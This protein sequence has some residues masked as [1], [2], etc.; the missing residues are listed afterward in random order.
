[1]KKLDTLN[2]TQR[3]ELVSFMMSRKRTGKEV[4]RVLAIQLIESKEYDTIKSLTGISK[5]QA[6]AI[7]VRYLDQGEKGLLD[8]PKGNPK[9][10]LTVTQRKRV[11]Q[12][13]TKKPHDFG[14]G[15]QPGWTTAMLGATIEKEMGVVYKSKT[16]LYLL[17]KES[18]FS[19]HFPAKRYERRSNEEV[20]AWE[21]EK[22]SSIKKA[23]EDTNTVLL[24]EDEMSLSSQT[25]TQK[26]WLP[27]GAKTE[28]TIAKKRESR[29][30]YGFLNLKTGQDHAFKTEWQNMYLTV[31]QLKKVRKIYPNK[32]LLILWDQAG[33]H[34]GSEVKKWIEA[35]KNTETLYFPAAAPD[36]NPQEHVWKAG[37]SAITHNQ[38]IPR[39]DDAA[40]SFVS[41]VNAGSFP[42]ELLGFRA[43]VLGLVS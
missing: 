40:D 6:F 3:Q 42:Y 31:E 18:K 25:T 5:S 8:R 32:H 38:V 41:Y 30:L 34:K 11:E 43:P 1:M 14:Y 22:K 20:A 29:S 21:N 33:W 27:I 2:D 28:I 10:L 16:S 13:L 7:R 23:W 37:R 19:Y 26:V 36:L 39:I 35:D 15:T 9:R 12:I 17:F 24:V 4:R